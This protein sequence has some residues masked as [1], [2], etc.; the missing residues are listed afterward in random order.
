MTPIRPAAL[1]STCSA[2]RSIL[3]RSVTSGSIRTCF[4]ELRDRGGP[5]AAAIEVPKLAEAKRISWV[6]LAFGI[7]TLIG[8]WAIIGVLADISG[9]LEVIKGALWGWVALAFVLASAPGR[10]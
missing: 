8:I 3:T 5:G 2:R 4:P 1:S 9:S 10:S 7:G 6:N